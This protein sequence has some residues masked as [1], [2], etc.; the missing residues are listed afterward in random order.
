MFYELVMFM[1]TL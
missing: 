1:L